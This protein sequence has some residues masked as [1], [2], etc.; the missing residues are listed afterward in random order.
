MRHS[1][2]GETR[3]SHIRIGKW[4]TVWE[5]IIIVPAEVAG[6]LKI[7]LGFCPIDSGYFSQQSIWNQRLSRIYSL[8]HV[9]F[10]TTSVDCLKSL[11][12]TWLMI[13][14]VSVNLVS[15]CFLNSPVQW[16]KCCE[17]QWGSTTEQQSTTPVNYCF[18]FSKA[19]IMSCNCG[20]VN[21]WTTIKPT[22][23]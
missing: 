20:V 22:G 7:H 11:F 14:P 18:F 1:S 5:Y 16:T 4:S 8:L 17:I 2:W 23:P 9:V 12:E 10:T 13:T 15:F 21:S 6:W 3:W 19:A